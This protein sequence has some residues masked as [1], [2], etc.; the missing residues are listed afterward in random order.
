[1]RAEYWFVNAKRIDVHMNKKKFEYFGKAF[2]LSYFTG[3]E[4]SIDIF[5]KIV[6]ELEK[7]KRE[8]PFK[9]RYVDMEPFQNIG[10]FVNW[11]ELIGFD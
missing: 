9:G 3:K 2:E 1:M 4:S 10:L 8:E 6:N 5:Q 11:R 7:L